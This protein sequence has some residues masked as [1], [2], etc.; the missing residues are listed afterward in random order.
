[1]SPAETLRA[2][3]KLLRKRGKEAT[4]GPWDD[5]SADGSAW[6]I[7]IHGGPIKDDPT[8]R[9][10]TVIKVHESIADEEIVAPDDAA[11]I[12]LMSPAVAEPLA[13]WLEHAA[14]DLETAEIA[15]TK[16]GD[17]EQLKPG[18]YIDEPDSAERAL[19]FARAILGRTS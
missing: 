15:A 19:A 18:D 8:D 6:P 10:D 1:M 11:W 7:L 13:A 4:P 17:A 3:A 9:R 2:A 5:H 12:A 16:W 14:T